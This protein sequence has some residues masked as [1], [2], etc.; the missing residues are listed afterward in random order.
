MLNKKILKETKIL[1]ED[2]EVP[3]KERKIPHYI[4][5]ES[6]LQRWRWD[7]INAHLEK[8]K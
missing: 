3:K 5:T 7:L 6:D 8:V 2:F 4:K 1:L